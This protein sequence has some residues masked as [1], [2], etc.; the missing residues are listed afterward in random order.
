MANEL[1]SL[2]VPSPPYT[3]DAAASQ[4]MRDVT[5]AIN[6]VPFSIF[7]TTAGPNASLVTAPQGFL[8]LEI[9]SSAT[10]HWVKTSGS[11]S[12]G[13][14]PLSLSTVPVSS[15]TWLPTL[16]NTANVSASSAYI[17]QWLRVGNNVTASGRVDVDPTLTATATSVYISP[18]V[19]SSFAATENAAGTAFASEITG[20]GAAIRA[21]AGNA[22]VE[23]A[24]VSTDITNQPMYYT[25]TYRVI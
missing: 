2:R 11:T 5:N 6:A 21:V 7:S 12:T 20:Q 19:S 24:W 25:F 3:S 4:W 17:G 1:R 14:S 13:W 22:N 23:M 18:P 16:A 9:G 15:G 8:G 10:K